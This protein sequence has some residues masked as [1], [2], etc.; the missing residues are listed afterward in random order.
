MRSKAAGFPRSQFGIRTSAG[1]VRHSSC[2][3]PFPTFI[4]PPTPACLQDSKR[5]SKLMTLHPHYIYMY[6][7]GRGDLRDLTTGLNKMGTYYY[8]TCRYLVIILRL[9]GI[10]AA[11]SRWRLRPGDDI[12]D[13]AKKLQ[14]LMKQASNSN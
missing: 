14:G 6:M 3:K 4:C 8:Q 13:I 2:P 11:V 12:T 1:Q 7:L 9:F 5:Y 10:H